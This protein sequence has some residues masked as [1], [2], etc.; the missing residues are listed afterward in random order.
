M[1][2]VSPQLSGAG[3]C[4]CNRRGLRLATTL[5]EEGLGWGK[6]S[7]VV[8]VAACHGAEVVSGYRGRL[9]RLPAMDEGGVGLSVGVMAC[10]A[11]N[12][13]FHSTPHYHR[14]TSSIPGTVLSAT[15]GV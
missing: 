11:R 9:P 6:V 7:G 1:S 3:A 4:P 12:R 5:S 14:D 8:V 10:L 15:L 13:R 2:I